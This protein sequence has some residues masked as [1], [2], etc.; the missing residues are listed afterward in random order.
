MILAGP[1]GVIMTLLEGIC[2]FGVGTFG[3][4]RLWN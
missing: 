4:T 1:F 3:G 2:L